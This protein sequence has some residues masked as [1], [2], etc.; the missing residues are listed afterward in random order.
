MSAIVWVIAIYVII[1][2]ILAAGLIRSG[3]Y[4]THNP[5]ER[6]LLLFVVY[7]WIALVPIFVLYTIGVCTLKIIAF[8]GGEEE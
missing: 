5:K 1:G 2:H 6:P 7:A 8:M 3:V 4:G